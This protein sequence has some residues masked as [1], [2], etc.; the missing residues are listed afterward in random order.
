MTIATISPAEL[1]RM[2]ADGRPIDLID[3]RTPAE[4][5]QVHLRC[6]RPV[7]LDKLDPAEL[8]RARNGCAGEPLYVICKAG[9]RGAKACEKLAA[10]GLEQVFNV[11]G[12]TDACIRAGLEVV[13]G[14]N[15]VISL[16]RQVRIAAG[17][18]VLLGAALG[19]FLS[20]WLYLLDAV[21]GCGL[22]FAG[23]TDFCGMG[24]LLAKMPWNRAGC[25]TCC[26][27]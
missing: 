13:R 25:G 6:A 3:V 16:E 2:I 26:T 20:P 4:F 11:E 22:I 1:Q 23:L 21:V 17:M 18:F 27:K 15:K 5:S 8:I 7:P 9:G 10:A 24:L 12:G 19:F 14:S